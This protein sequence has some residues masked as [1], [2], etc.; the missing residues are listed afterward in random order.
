MPDPNSPASAG[1]EQITLVE[2]LEVETP[3][4]AP[5]GA[6]ELFGRYRVL[7]LLGSGGMG[8][9]YRVWDS[10]LEDEVALKMLRT[11]LLAQPGFIA[12][13]RQEVKLARR[14]THPN[15]V[16]TFDLGEREGE[17]YLTMEYIRGRSARRVLAEEGAPPLARALEIARQ[18]AAGIGAA[19][20]SGVI[21]CDLKPDNLL[22][23]EGGRVAITDFGIARVL[24]GREGAIA[25]TPAYMAPEVAIRGQV[26]ARSDLYSLG[27]V[28][29]E[30]VTGRS[31]WAEPDLRRGPALRL[32]HPAP[33]PRAQGRVPDGLAELIQALLAPRPEDRPSSAEELRRML[34]EVELEGGRR[35]TPSP[36]GSMPSPGT[37]SLAVL[38]FHNAGAPEDQHLAEGLTEEIIDALSA[39]RGLRVRPL[40]STPPARA[41]GGALATGRALDVQAVVEG[42]VRR[43]AGEVVLAVRL[44]GVADG[45]Q[46]WA[47]RFRCGT[48]DALV[49]AEEVARAI[50]GALMVELAQSARPASSDPVALDLYLRARSLLRSLWDASAVEAVS[51]L[52]QS[53]ARRPDNPDALAIYAMAL[54]RKAFFEQR[55]G[56]E[57]VAILDRMRFAADQAVKLAPEQG[58]AWLALG[59]AQL[60]AGRAPEAARALREAVRRAPGLARAQ[61]MLGSLA[62]EVG[63]VEE[64]FERLQAALSIDPDAVQ[65]RMDLARGYA[66]LGL[67]QQVDELLAGLSGLGR[68]AEALLLIQARLSLWAP[69]RRP[70]PPDPGPQETPSGRMAARVVGWYAHVHAHGRVPDDFEHEVQR[71]GPDALSLLRAVQS[72][73]AAELFA[74]TGH[75]EGAITALRA[76]VDAGLGD[77]LWMERC[78]ALA[79]VRQHPDWENLRA[80]VAGRA[81]TLRAAL[82]GR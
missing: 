32:S 80:I 20:A 77:L 19:H 68:G 11:D 70:P 24:G 16:R 56:P 18:V 69:G 38:P 41:E 61:Q 51:L 39:T 59:A 43:R 64:A 44:I 6:A 31:P 78:P 35:A 37:P 46:L 52:E 28:L 63:R 53:L 10:F 71:R 22:L 14:I 47:R 50:A 62:L 57:L 79:P 29:H 58:D 4:E 34:D 36:R 5:A 60:Y 55:R 42:T 40:S 72:Q 12:R 30:L 8:A 17:Y 81:A 9:V 25:G 66:L 48:G 74:A 15:V 75:A 23:D 65:A 33:D 67:W 82:E 45:F 7:G 76:S 54:A 73:Y 2:L 13:F 26:D 49:V 3:A 1:V 27:V 21:H